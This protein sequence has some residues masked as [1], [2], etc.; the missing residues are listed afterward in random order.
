LF[1]K[2]PR[3]RQ[4]VAD[5]W[6]DEFTTGAR[7]P[8]QGYRCVDGRE[9]L[10]DGPID[11]W[12]SIYHRSILPLLLAL[13]YSEYFPI[14]GMVRQRLQ[15]QGL[16]GLLC[17]RMKVFHVIGPQ[18]ASFF[19]MLD[20]EVEKYRRLGRRDILDWYLTARA[21]LP[22]AEVMAGHFAAAARSIDR[23]GGESA[24]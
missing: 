4:L 6:Q 24:W 23:E 2:F 15:R 17:T 7:P 9:G 11:G 1:A 10:Y 20:A 3:V 18:Y 13:P 5:V 16:R 8:I 21:T 22:S 19:G 14:G 12:F